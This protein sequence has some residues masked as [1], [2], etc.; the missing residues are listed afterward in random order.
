M[1]FPR[2]AAYCG[3]FLLLFSASVVPASADVCADFR[4]GVGKLVNESKV[5]QAEMARVN[6]IKPI[7]RSDVKLCAALR[8]VFDRSQKLIFDA[9]AVAQCFPKQQL[10]EV[11]KDIKW[12]YRYS[13]EGRG[14]YHCPR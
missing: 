2:N 3:V 1:T 4:A 12:R 6:R 13:A 14:L 7:P 8:K 5:M 9:I 11:T 10:D